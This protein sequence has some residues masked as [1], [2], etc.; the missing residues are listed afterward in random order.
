MSRSSSSGD[1]S[2]DE[3][4]ADEEEVEETPVQSDEE[5]EE[6]EEKEVQEEST[7]DQTKV[8]KSGSIKGVTSAEYKREYY[9]KNR[10]RILKMIK[11]RQAATK[12]AR[13]KTI[14]DKKRLEII[15]RLNNKTYKRRPPT[16]RLLKYNI[17]FDESIKKYR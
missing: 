14:F 1:S 12:E 9:L 3:S 17:V 15:G 5:D 11:A 8:N 16:E 2:Y 4:I 7:Q 10:E 13:Q 6:Q